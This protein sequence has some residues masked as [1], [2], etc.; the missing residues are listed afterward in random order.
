MVLE[1][2]SVEEVSSTLRYCNKIKCPIV[3]FGTGTGLEGGSICTEVR[4]LCIE[5]VFQP[6]VTMSLL[7][8]EG[9]VT[10]VN[11]EDFDC[12][13]RPSVTR[14]AL[15]EHIRNTGLFFPI[16]KLQLQS[17]HGKKLDPGADASVCGMVA[18]GASGT[19]TVRYGLFQ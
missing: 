6:A 5:H 9:G 15:N 4:N 14:I 1:P 13:V 18:T 10:S 11:S 16:G 3:P 17:K 12:S 2:T 19:N 7:Q 8:L